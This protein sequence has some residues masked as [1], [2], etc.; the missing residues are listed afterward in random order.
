MHTIKEFSAILISVGYVEAQTSALIVIAIIH[1]HIIGLIP[2][3]DI[4]AHITF[5][6]FIA[7]IEF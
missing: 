4:A 6:K 7:G 5:V 3:A 2:V 1:A